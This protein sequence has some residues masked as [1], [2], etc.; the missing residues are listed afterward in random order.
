[1]GLLREKLAAME[2]A[3]G[4][5]SS[6]DIEQT[7]QLAKMTQLMKLAAATM[8][9]VDPTLA[10]SLEGVA[11][12]NRRASMAIQQFQQHHLY[13]RHHLY[14]FYHRHH[15]YHFHRQLHLHQQSQ[16]AQRHHHYLEHH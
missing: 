11:T 10:T 16:Q 5:A 9:S 13:Q 14:R 4:R 7:A 15:P 2:A 6:G 3:Q 8:R 1:M 12:G